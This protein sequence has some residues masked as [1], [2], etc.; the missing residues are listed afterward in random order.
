MANN[1]GL[2]SQVRNRD[3]RGGGRAG[4]GMDQQRRVQGK[5]LRPHLPGHQ[6]GPRLPAAGSGAGG[7]RLRRDPPL[8]ARLP[9]VRLLLPLHPE[10]SLPRAGAGGLRLH[11]RGRRGVRRPEQPARGAGERHR[12]LQAEDDAD[13]HLLHAGDHRRRPD[14][15]HQERPATRGSFPRTSRC[16]TPIPRAST[17]PTSTA[18]TPCSSPS[19]RP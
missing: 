3:P 1:L 9:G 7:P 14:R 18:T 19:S 2:S 17:A 16:P 10:P 13:L 12:P 6:P 5:E 15:L 11:D 4:C 8:C